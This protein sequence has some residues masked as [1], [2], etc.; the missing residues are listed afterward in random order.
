MEQ[1]RSD[2]R[3][4]FRALAKSPGFALVV[5]LTLAI[6]IG[7]NAAIFSMVNAA[8][9]QPLPFADSHRIVRIFNEHRT[10]GHDHINVSYPDL[11]DFAAHTRNACR[12]A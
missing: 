4:A 7:A 8:L 1:I 6:G 3:Y 11:Q 9:F 12:P 10:R 5:I 2:V